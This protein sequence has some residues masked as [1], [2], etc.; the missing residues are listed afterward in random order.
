MRATADIVIIGAGVIGCSTAYHLAKMGMRNIVVVEMG[1]V[2]NGSSGKSASMLSL[3]FCDDELTVQMANYSY[4]KYMQF[5]EELGTSID[6][7]KIGWLSL[8]TKESAEKLRKNAELLRSLDV[9][10]E[11]WSPREIK[12][13]YPE[14]HTEDLVLGTW[15]QEDG[16]FDPHMIMWGYMKRASEMGVR[17]HQGEKAIGIEFRN[18]R[19]GG[20]KT[21]KCFLSTEVVVN[22]GGPWAI[23]I[24]S[25]V[26]IRIPIINLV[27]GI[28]VTGP[29]PEI[30][31]DR[32]FVEDLTKEW[33]Y[34]PEGP[35]VLMGM[36]AIPTENLE[37]QI[38]YEMMK[39]MIETAAHRVPILEKASALTAW[40]GIRPLT[41]DNLPILGPVPSVKGF[42]L[43]CG[44]GGMGI[45]LAPLGGQLIAEYIVNGYSLTM[46]ITPFR[47]E[48]FA[49]NP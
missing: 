29:I 39:E 15:G 43:N 7:K 35:G 10:T 21:D 41:E 36:G 34:R 31:S 9:R 11:I 47:M 48:R 1:Q 19:V 30:P 14:I 44:W 46:D 13:R 16:V 28:L 18:G 22:A 45:I 27:R 49:R 25:W 23:E 8:A 3:Q 26:G 4:S 12:E 42:I 37:V 32:P 5:Q 38:N 17:L 24:G 33:Y 2:G 6:F 40:A 20:V